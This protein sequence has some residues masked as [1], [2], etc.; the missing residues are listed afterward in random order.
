LSVD[1][2]RAI[3]RSGPVEFVVEDFVGRP[4]RWI[5]GADV[6]DFWKQDVRQHVA[7]PNERV[8][9]DDFTPEYFYWARRWWPANYPRTVIDLHTVD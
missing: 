7:H 6:F 9:L 8:Y 1:D 4:V 3:L 2:V 5:A